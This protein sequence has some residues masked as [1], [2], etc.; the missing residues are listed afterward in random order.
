MSFNIRNF[1][2]G[3]KNSELKNTSLTLTLIT[4]LSENFFFT[5]AVGQIALYSDLHRFVLFFLK[6]N[7]FNKYDIFS[8]EFVKSYCFGFFGRRMNKMSC[9]ILNILTAKLLS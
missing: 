2:E 5:K 7:S 9:C 8:L 4:S 3:E 6:K 1:L